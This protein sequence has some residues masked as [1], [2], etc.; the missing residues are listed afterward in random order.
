[1]DI[2][3]SLCGQ[4][5]IGGA[6]IWYLWYTTAVAQPRLLREHRTTVST[7]IHQFRDDLREERAS[8][9]RLA[10]DVSELVGQLKILPCASTD[11]KPKPR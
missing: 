9:V 1:M 5:G 7:L 3:L 8:R 4:A 11:A 10:E 2:L 6:L